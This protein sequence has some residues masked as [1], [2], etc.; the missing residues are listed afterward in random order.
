MFEIKSVRTKI[1]LLSVL[2]IILTVGVLLAVLE[3]GRQG[4]E[5]DVTKELDLLAQNEVIKLAKSVFL[6]CRTQNEILSQQL[7]GN[8]EVAKDLIA[9]SGGMHKSTEVITWEAI[10]QNTKESLKINL[11]KV[12]L[13]ETWLG[14]NGDVSVPSLI[15]DEVKKVVG[16][17]C[18]LFQRMNEEGDLLRICTNVP[19]ADGKRAIGTYMPSKQADGSPN[20]VVQKV[21]SGQPF[22]GRVRMFGKD[23]LTQYEPVTDAQGK[24][25]G[26][27]Y[28]G[29]DILSIAGIRQGIID[30][31]VGKTGYVSIISGKGAQQGT[32][33]ISKDGKRDGENIWGQADA[34]GNLIIQE[35]VKKGLETKDGDS[36]IV[37]YL[38]KNPEDP[39]PRRK[40]GAC[41]YFESWDWVIIPSAYQDDF[42]DAQTH[43]TDSMKRMVK[44]CFLAAILLAILLIVASFLVANGISRPLR[45]AVD[46]AEIVAEGDLTQQVEVLHNDEVGVLARTLNSMSSRLREAFRQV[47]AESQSVMGQATDLTS[48]AQGM[49]ASAEET[50]SQAG[51][52]AAATEE[53]SATIA[54][55][56]GNAS[57]MASSVD[58]VASAMEEM[59]A[60]LGEVARHTAHGTETA[61]KA[62]QRAKEASTAMARLSVAAQEIGMVVE[63]INAIAGQTNL[64]ALNATIEAAR[65]GE[66]GKG[67]AVVA[68]EVKDLAAQTAKATDEIKTRVDAIQS[69]TKS[70]LVQIEDTVKTIEEMKESSMAIASAVQ[71]QSVTT[72]EISQSLLVASSA[73]RDIAKH[74]EEASK[75]AGEISMNIMGVNSAAQSTAAG[76][77]QTSASA[78]HLSD[79]AERLQE[80]VGKF[81]V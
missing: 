41:S 26:A 27:I 79:L 8:V 45:K 72:A 60:S 49:A 75:A 34:S 18:T 67:F 50:T 58:N 74:V 22:K 10:N 15:V 23:Y 51:V 38:W 68:N 21:L 39:Q 73:A 25:I 46:L 44:L 6:L 66:A 62:D 47:A 11:P 64:L 33:V 57:E 71:E 4:M 63:T 56:S 80:M 53:M 30:M 77:T 9:R 13:G 7:A 78:T 70:S 55:V 3:V 65:A 59:N 52:V 20:E 28:S 76:A 24:V 17:T 37:H 35:I 29:V 48:L 14:Q 32:Y 5:Q 81:K 40:I 42:L 54:G 12:M 69:E 2:S 31:K 43:M 16:G 36:Q 61:A 1:A 19:T